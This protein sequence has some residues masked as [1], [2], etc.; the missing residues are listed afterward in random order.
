M[1]G[2]TGFEPATTCTPNADCDR[3]AGDG[4]SQTVAT[5]GTS[6]PAGVQPSQREGPKTNC[7]AASLLLGSGSPGSV[8]AWLEHQD[9]LL[10]VREV[11]ERLRVSRASV[12]KLVERGEIACVRVM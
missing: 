7:F 12:Y 8:A 9:E 10:T 6:D 1:V 4:N 2:A 11:A 5:T 3:P